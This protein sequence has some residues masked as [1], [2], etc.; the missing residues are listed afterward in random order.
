MAVKK[1]QQAIKYPVELEMNLKGMLK[2]I[3]RKRESRGQRALG[4]STLNEMVMRQY[5]DNF[6][7]NLKVD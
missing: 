2:I 1:K 5:H 3:N 6:M 4:Y 7:K